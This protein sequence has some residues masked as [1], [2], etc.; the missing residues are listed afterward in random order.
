MCKLPKEGKSYFYTGYTIA[1]IFLYK[2]IIFQEVQFSHY[3]G[4]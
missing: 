1:M 2:R 3:P 4:G